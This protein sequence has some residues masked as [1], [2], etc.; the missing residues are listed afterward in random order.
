MKL[1][2]V[3]YGQIIMTEEITGNA[4]QKISHQYLEHAQT[5]IN[6]LAIIINRF[7]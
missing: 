1:K 2:W 5:L 7:V 4:R 3:F 6:G